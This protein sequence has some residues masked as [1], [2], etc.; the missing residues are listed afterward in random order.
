MSEVDRHR[1][2][3]LPYQNTRLQ[4]A[5]RKATCAFEAPLLDT[6]GKPEVAIPTTVWVEEVQEEL[7]AV[8]ID[9]D[10]CEYGSQTWL[11]HLCHDC[12]SSGCIKTYR[13][14][15]KATVFGELDFFD[16]GGVLS[17]CAA[18]T[19]ASATAAPRLSPWHAAYFRALSVAL[20]PLQLLRLFRASLSLQ[21]LRLP[22]LLLGT[23]LLILF[24]ILKFQLYLGFGGLLPSLLCVALSSSAPVGATSSLLMFLPCTSVEPCGCCLSLYLGSW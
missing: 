7:P 6:W 2:G 9:D 21:L 11:L 15:Y 8:E 3:T 22:L 13:T 18:A 4:T 1:D 16:D 20:L 10:E 5:S 23:L 24:L 12:G 14:W 17:S 19:P